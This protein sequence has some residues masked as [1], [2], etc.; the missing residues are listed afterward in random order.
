MSVGACLV[1]TASMMTAPMAM[2]VRY[3]NV[4]PDKKNITSA[5]IIGK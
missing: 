1:G 3:C 2:Y 4:Y 5:P